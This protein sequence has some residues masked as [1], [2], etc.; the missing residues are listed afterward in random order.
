MRKNKGLV[1]ELRETIDKQ[2]IALSDQAQRIAQLEQRLG[3]VQGQLS[4]IEELDGAMQNARDEL[5]IQMGDLRKEHQKRESDA[6][7]ARQ[8]ERERDARV[9]NEVR[10]ELSRFEPL[11]QSTASLQAE[12]QRQNEVLLRLQEETQQQSRRYAQREDAVQVLAERL[13]RLNVRVG[14]RD[15]AEQEL[16]KAQETLASRVLATES[17]LP[18]LE[19][20]LAELQGMRS[21]ITKGQEA[22]LETQ[23]LAD[24]Q[25][26]QSLT[27]W[28]RKIESFAHQIDIWTDQMRF[29]ADQ[30]EK[31][32]SVLREV[33][34]LTHQISQ[35]QDQLKQVQRIAEDQIRQE[36]LEFRTETEQ[37]LAQEV[38]RR[39]VFEQ[40]QASREDKQTQRIG[41]LEELRKQDVARADV[42]RRSIGEVER[43]LVDSIEHLREAMLSVERKRADAAKLTSTDLQALLGE[44]G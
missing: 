13:E 3:R 36:I 33:Q 1:T 11:E 30:Y 35:Q 39:K 43:R 26:A 21:E 18:P 34:E 31:N 38:E 17:A 16:R 29:Y 14:Q 12:D 44:K 22:L 8:E 41:D 25:R 32:R 28:G 5:V 4:R 27:E 7:R 19:Q 2:Q 24:R 6:V 9:L 10:A 37:R 42:T 23:R 15:E 20:R 40:Q